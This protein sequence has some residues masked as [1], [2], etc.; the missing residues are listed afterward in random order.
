[1]TNGEEPTPAAKAAAS[2]I[3]VIAA[4]S[5]FILLLLLALVIGGLTGMGYWA[6]LI[7]TG[8][9]VL[10]LMSMGKRKP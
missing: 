10:W 5:G 4:V 8:M 9:F 3:V 6:L 7:P 2:A 1:M